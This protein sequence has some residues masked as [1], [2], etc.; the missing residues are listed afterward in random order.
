MK[1]NQ[2]TRTHSK[3]R[4]PSATRARDDR[5]QAI[6][7]SRTTGR[8]S[9]ET[10]VQNF[11]TIKARPRPEKAQNGRACLQCCTRGEGTDGSLTRGGDISSLPRT[12]AS[13]VAPVSACHWPVEL[14]EN[15]F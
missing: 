7:R 5:F 14:T 12:L 3:V 8:D 13:I 4:E 11:A 10:P 15:S 1:A 2:R 9:G 6:R